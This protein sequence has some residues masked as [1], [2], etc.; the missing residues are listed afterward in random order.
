MIAGTMNFISTALR[1]QPAIAQR[2]IAVESATS[3]MRAAILMQ[4]AK[5]PEGCL[6]PSTLPG[7][8]FDTNGTDTQV[9]CT[10]LEALDTSNGRL[11]RHHHAVRRLRTRLLGLA[12]RHR[13]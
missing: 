6:D 3:A 1:S 13:R 10:V 5:G 2:S 9:G 12:R 4:V 8:T 11:R 7:E